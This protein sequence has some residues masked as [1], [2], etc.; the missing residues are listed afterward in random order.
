MI[1]LYSTNSKNSFRFRKQTSNEGGIPEVVQGEFVDDDIIETPSSTE[2]EPKQSFR[3]RFVNRAKSLRDKLPK[4]T[5]AK[6]VIGNT[7]NKVAKKTKGLRNENRK[8]GLVVYDEANA[9]SE[10]REKSI[11][12]LKSNMEAFGALSNS[13]KAKVLA[14]LGLSTAVIAGSAAFLAPTILGATVGTGGV[15]SVFGANSFGTYGFLSALGTA[16]TASMGAFTIKAGVAATGLGLGT[17]A[18]GLGM[19][20]LDMLKNGRSTRQIGGTSELTLEGKEQS[21]QSQNAL[22]SGS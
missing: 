5:K 3:Q 13:E 16:K 19:K 15:A 4:F 17:I 9:S 8:Q 20:T 7:W 1:L 10:G 11:S 12:W 22:P 18:T 6:E 14:M 21:P 2:S